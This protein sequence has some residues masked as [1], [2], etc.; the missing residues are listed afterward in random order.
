MTNIK[1]EAL[2]AVRSFAAAHGR[3]WKVKLA[4][5]WASG[6]DADDPGLRLAR[7]LL[8]PSGLAALTPA[9]LRRG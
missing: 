9:Q 6:G 4:A 1:S 3:C 5:L 8:G 2:A 7:N